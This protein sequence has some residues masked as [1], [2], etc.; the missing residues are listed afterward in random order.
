MARPGPRMEAGKAI[1]NLKSYEPP[2]SPDS[3]GSWPY[4]T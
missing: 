1:K 2:E 3:S 4:I